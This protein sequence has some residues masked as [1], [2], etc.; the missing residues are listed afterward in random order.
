MLESSDVLDSFFPVRADLQE[1][2][3]KNRDG[4]RK[5]LGEGA[6]GVR[7]Q[8]RFSRILKNVRQSSGDFRKEWISPAARGFGQLMSSIVQPDEIIPG[9]LRLDRQSGVLPQILQVLGGILQ[10]LFE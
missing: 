10:K 4:V 2:E 7:A 3:F 5:K 8:L 9:R 6:V 1:I